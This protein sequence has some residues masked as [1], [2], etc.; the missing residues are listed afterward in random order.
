MV[1]PSRTARF[2]TASDTAS[3]FTTR[4]EAESSACFVR[5]DQGTCWSTAPVSVAWRS[6]PGTTSLRRTGTAGSA[7]KL[8]IRTE[9]SVRVLSKDLLSVAIPAGRGSITR[10]FTRTSLRSRSREISTT[11]SISQRRL[12]KEFERRTSSGSWCRLLPPRPEERS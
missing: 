12:S 7:F 9:P 8:F 3:T 6:M 1:R 11:K 4:P 10:C 2:V 5:Q